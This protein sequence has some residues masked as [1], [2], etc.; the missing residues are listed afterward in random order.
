M[1][2]LVTG[3]AGFMAGHL[4][5]ALVEAGH[6]VVAAARDESQV[7]AWSGVE[8]LGLDLDRP[9]DDGAVPAVDAVVHLAQANVPFPDKAGELFRVNTLSTQ[10]LLEH[11][12]RCGAQRFVYA[13]SGLVYGFADEERV[14]TDPL[15]PPDFYAATKA[16]AEHL[17]RSYQDFLGTTILRFYAPYGPGQTGRLVPAL[18][19]RVRTGSPV[20]LNGGGRPRMQPV[21]VAD[22]VRL[23]ARTLDSEG[24]HV[25]NVA[26]DEVASIRDLAELIGQAAGREPVFEEGD[27][28]VAGD[29][30]ADNSCVKNL[31]ELAPLVPLAEGLRQTVE[32]A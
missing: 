29:L 20:T 3:A 28:P 23:I 13:S 14:E 18:I 19:G 2:V 5:P 21:F 17:V 26:G 22:V 10:G 16:A 6:Q 11:A 9:L 1:R 31:F 32:A 27:S 8:R 30:L 4:V 12:R 25:L 15:L 7:P 24:D